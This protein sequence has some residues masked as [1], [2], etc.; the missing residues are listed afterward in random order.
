[1]VF[2]QIDAWNPYRISGLC[3]RHFRSITRI[4]F[5]IS[6]CMWMSFVAVSRNLWIFNNVTF[7]MAAWQPYWIF[8]CDQEALWMVQSVRPSLSVC[9]SATPF[10]PCFH[11]RIIM[12]FAGVI[13][14]DRSYVH[15]KVKV[16]GQSSGH[17]YHNPIYPF[18]DRN[19]N[20]NAPMI[21]MM[22]KAWCCLGKE[23]YCNS[24]S[25]IKL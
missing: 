11:H 18:P 3:R 19:S 25:S 6:S 5:A 10:L 9:P 1:M 13:N 2:S 23:P 24:R 8:S 7:I 17:R 21:K 12:E 4:C 15:A 14:N 20:F 16:R 22:H